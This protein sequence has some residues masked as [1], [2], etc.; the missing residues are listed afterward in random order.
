MSFA[1]VN[2]ICVTTRLRNTKGTSQ[3]SVP[4]I[5]TLSRYGTA[6][7]I[8]HSPKACSRNPSYITRLT[9]SNSGQEHWAVLCV[10]EFCPTNSI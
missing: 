9:V 6:L 1:L 3:S 4:L 5:C 10:R 2:G 7:L 8:I